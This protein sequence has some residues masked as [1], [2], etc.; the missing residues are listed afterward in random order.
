VAQFHVEPLGREHDRAAFTCGKD[1]L[2]D[3]LKK[4][5]NQD[6]RRN[7]T[8]AFVLAPDDD[9]TV[10]AGFYTLS[11]F[12][13]DPGTLPENLAKKYPKL[14]LPCTLIGRLAVAVSYQKQGLGDALLSHALERSYDAGQEIAAIGVVVDALDDEAESFYLNSEFIPLPATSD[15]VGKTRLIMMMDTIERQ[16]QFAAQAE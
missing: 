14:P 10:I 15:E 9:P 1:P 6:V 4:T 8:R 2:D 7:M 3:Y 5:I 11:Q 13:I 12:S 16:L